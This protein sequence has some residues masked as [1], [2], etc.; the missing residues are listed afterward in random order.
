[1]F[2]TLAET[3]MI[4]ARMEPMIGKRHP[5]SMRI[6]LMIAENEAKK[7]RNVERLHEANAQAR[8]DAVRQFFAR[9]LI[10]FGEAVSRMGDRLAPQ[11][12]CCP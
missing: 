6:A 1:M 12:Q 3:Y 9:I 7:A 4:A 5:E 10:A 11:G 8:R 2:T